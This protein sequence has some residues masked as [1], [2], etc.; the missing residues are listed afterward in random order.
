VRAAINVLSVYNFLSKILPLFWDV[1]FLE[2][3]YNR[4]KKMTISSNKIIFL[5]L[6]AKIETIAA[7]TDNFLNFFRLL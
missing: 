4:V 2:T 1:Y 3:L 6:N 7:L 5:T